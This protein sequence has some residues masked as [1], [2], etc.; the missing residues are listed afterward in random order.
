MLIGCSHS[1]RL[2]TPSGSTSKIA[3][4]EG[5]PVTPDLKGVSFELLGVERPTLHFK[6]VDTLFPVSIATSGGVLIYPLPVGHW[7]LTGIEAQGQTYSSINISRKFVL[8]IKSG[9]LNY[10]GSIIL[11][12]PQIGS[13]DLKF[14]KAMKFF[15]RYPFGGPSGVCELVIGNNLASVRRELI[16]LRKFQKLRIQMSF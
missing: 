1:E 9:H 14:L 16:K 6:N 5:T 8:N 13:R 15:N 7:E 4:K 2:N 11:G 3:P 12:C 10:G